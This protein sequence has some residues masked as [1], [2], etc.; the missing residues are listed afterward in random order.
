[1]RFEMIFFRLLHLLAHHP[2]FGTTEETLPDIA[3]YVGQSSHC[4]HLLMG[5]FRYIEFYL[6]LV[7]S[8]DNIPLLFHLAVK[9]KTVRDIQSHAY[10]EV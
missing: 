4:L 2:D 8:P 9:A 3:K 6:D 10:S 5:S 7:A 1:M